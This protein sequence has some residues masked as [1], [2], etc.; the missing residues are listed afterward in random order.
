[1]TTES[2]DDLDTSPRLMSDDAHALYRR[3][4]HRGGGWWQSAGGVDGA[5]AQELQRL[6]LLVRDAADQ[7]WVAADPQVTAA[8]LTLKLQAQAINLLSHAARVPDSLR[9]L[10]DAYQQL[11]Q[12]RPQGA[13]ESTSVYVEGVEN[14]RAQLSDLASRCT[15]EASSMQATGPQRYLTRQ[16]A[17]SVEGPLVRSGVRSRA[18][19]QSHARHDPRHRGVIKALT[20]AGCQIRIL[21]EALPH[22][23]IFDRSWVVICMPEDPTAALVTSD[24]AIAAYAAR[25]FERDWARA[26]P[27]DE[28]VS[29]P[30][31]L[32][33]QQEAILRMLAGGDSQ[34]QIAVKLN[35]S[36]RTVANHVGRIR[37]HYGV[38][39]IFQLALAVGREQGRRS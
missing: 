20:K 16:E 1:M 21:D 18:L 3:I 13:G 5:A 2:P 36:E 35:L 29:E 38:E 23:Y 33:S 9:V 27:Y 32:S 22:L 26:A 12:G 28:S 31:R 14:I 19:Y 34:P 39:T 30:G 11:E 37:A 7:H 10:S 8:Q 15:R 24:P 17:T 4:L 6:G 25:V